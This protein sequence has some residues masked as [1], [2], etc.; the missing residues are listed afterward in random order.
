M[1]F[2][3]K[4]IIVLYA[5]LCFAFLPFIATALDVPKLDQ[6]LMDYAGL[7]SSSENEEI[8]NY[9]LDLDRNTNMQIAVLIIPSLEGENLE[10]FSMRVAES[11]Q[12]GDKGKDSGAILLIAL[13]D[14]KLRIEV[15]YGLEENLTDARC[16][17][18]IRSVIAPNFKQGDYALGVFDGVKAMAGF[19]LQDETLLEGVTVH[20]EKESNSIFDF[21]IFLLVLNSFLCRFLGLRFFWPFMLLSWIARGRRGSADFMR[22]GHRSGGVFFG[23]SSSSSSGSSFGGGFSGGGGSFGG[24][25]SSGGW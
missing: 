5:V 4:K 16:S 9:L 19:A 1:N 25:G 14:K 7:L 15:G 3:K 23:G 13:D 20:K 10:D 8:N 24:G 18:I 6:P 2:I 11:W 17:K 21:I 22:S 12:I